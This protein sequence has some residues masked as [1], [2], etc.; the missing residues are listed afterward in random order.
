MA[1]KLRIGHSA[2][3]THTHI[4]NYDTTT[5]EESDESTTNGVVAIDINIKENKY[6]EKVKKNHRSHVHMDMSQIHNVCKS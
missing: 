3:I 4:I 2:S 1:A 6:G 5:F